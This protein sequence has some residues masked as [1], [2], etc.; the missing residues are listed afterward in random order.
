MSEVKL[1]PCHSESNEACL[2]QAGT[3]LPLECSG[4]PLLF[5][6]EAGLADSV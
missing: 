6:R 2:T 4:L 1:R 5:F 3:C